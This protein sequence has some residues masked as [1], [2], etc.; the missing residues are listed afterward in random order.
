MWYPKNH[1]LRCFLEQLQSLLMTQ[2]SQQKI[3]ALPLHREL[4]VKIYHFRKYPYIVLESGAS[5]SST[6][7]VLQKSKPMYFAVLSPLCGA[8][9]EGFQLALLNTCYRFTNIPNIVIS[10]LF[11]QSVMHSKRKR[12]FCSGFVNVYIR[13][14]EEV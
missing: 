9:S 2:S 5:N 6:M 11:Y 10:N 8:L 3:P 12:M 4:G 1:T 13:T 7:H 14:F